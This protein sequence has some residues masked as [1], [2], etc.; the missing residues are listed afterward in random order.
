VRV[1]G[2]WGERR[3]TDDVATTRRGRWEREPVGQVD[4]DARSAGCEPPGHPGWGA[5]PSAGVPSGGILARA[6]GCCI[7]NEVS[8]PCSR[9]SVGARPVAAGGMARRPQFLRGLQEVRGGCAMTRVPYITVLAHFMTCGQSTCTCG[10][11]DD[12]WTVLSEVGC[13][14]RFAPLLRALVDGGQSSHTPRPVATPG[15]PARS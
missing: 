4:E 2:V 11:P 1:G 6:A 9:S 14:T 10:P 3:R 8:N 13:M 12:S 5:R 7:C 15:L